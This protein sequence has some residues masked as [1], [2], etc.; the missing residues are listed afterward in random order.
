MEEVSIDKVERIE[1]HPFLRDF[2]YVFGK[3]LGPPPKRDFDFA[4]ALVP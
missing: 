3:I 2:E 4:T 1:D